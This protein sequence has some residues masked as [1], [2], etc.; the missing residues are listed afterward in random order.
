MKNVLDF[1]RS[2]FLGVATQPVNKR[3]VFMTAIAGVKSLLSRALLFHWD[4]DL[5]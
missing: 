3:Q 1:F 4:I 5:N 2:F